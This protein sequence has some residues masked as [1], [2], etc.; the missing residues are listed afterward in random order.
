[1]E[2]C[3]ML[4]GS[5][6]GRGLWR[7]MNKCVCMAESLCCPPETITTLLISYAWH[8]NKNFFK[9][10]K[11]GETLF[12]DNSM[13]YLE[14]SKESIT[15]LITRDSITF[16]SVQF[17]RS[18]VYD[19]LWPRGLQHARP[20]CPLPTPGVYPN[21][22]PLSWW[23]HP[24]TT[25]SVVPFSSCFQSFPASG[26]FPMSQFFESGGQSIEVSA[27]TSVFPMNI[28]DWFPLGWTGWISQESSPTPQF[29]SINSSGLN[30]PYSPT[31]TSIHDYWKNHSL[32]VTIPKDLQGWILS[33]GY[34][35]MSSLGWKWGLTLQTCKVNL[36]VFMPLPVCPSC[37]AVM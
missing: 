1:M 31:L 18:V 3:S 23:C 20:P 2:L 27:S 37:R 32:E 6:D 12:S 26:S 36:L 5:L 13:L 22:C 14:N 29:K 10:L 16:S 30:F 21:S 11:R 17:S 19:S 35:A 28:Q 9:N 4:C 34:I 25:S 7:R 33:W 15:S 24:T 8:Q